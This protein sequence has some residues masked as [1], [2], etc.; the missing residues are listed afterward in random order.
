MK[1][2]RLLPALVGLGLGVGGFCAASAVWGARLPG[3]HPDDAL[4]AAAIDRGGQIRRK[5]I[6]VDNWTSPEILDYLSHL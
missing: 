3:P 1:R 5:F 2:S 6:I 4:L